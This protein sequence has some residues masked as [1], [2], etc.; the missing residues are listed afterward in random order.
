MIITH[1][2]RAVHTCA[3]STRSQGAQLSHVGRHI[4]IP[5]GATSPRAPG[6]GSI[7]QAG[8][9]EEGSREHS[10]RGCRTSRRHRCR[11]R[12]CRTRRDLR[13]HQGGSSG[14]R[15]RPGEPQQPRWAGV[16]VAGRTL[17]RRHSR[18]ASSRH[19]RFSGTRPSGLDGLCGFRPRRRGLLASTVGSRLRR[20]R[21]HR[22]ASVPA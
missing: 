7:P 18:A 9:I 13:T 6:I 15:R 2:T 14:D 11:V 1:V 5:V 21:S 17:P 12:P 20:L 8:H 19:P 22:E 10:A 3:A 4:S 16:L